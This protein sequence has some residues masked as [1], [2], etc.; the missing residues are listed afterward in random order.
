MRIYV[1]DVSQ[2]LTSTTFTNDTI[3]FTTTE[4]SIGGSVSGANLTTGDIYLV[5]FDPTSALEF[6]TESVRRRFTDTNG[7]PLYLGNN[8]ELPTGSR[9]VLYLGHGDSDTWAENRG[10]A[11]STS[12]TKNGTIANVGTVLN[13]QFAYGITHT[14]TP[15]RTSWTDVGSPTVTGRYCQ[16]N[17]KCYFQIK[18]V[19]ATTVATTAGTS[20]TSL[21]LTAN[22]ADF[23]GDGS[24]ENITTLI[25]VGSCVFDLTN[26]RCYVPT[27]AATGNTLE[28]AGW[29]PV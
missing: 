11:T 26:N 1:D 4:H 6:N 18:V 8:G 9:P 2:S 7:V 5:W 24:M 3:D 27:Q 22:P 15:S 25:A 19:P 28:I 16:I 12:F 20:Y 14:W 13:G 23:T 29:Y 10:S 21:P 17:D